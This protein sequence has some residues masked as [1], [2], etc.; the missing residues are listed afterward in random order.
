MSER[1]F[2]D[3]E[4]ISTLL[5]AIRLRFP[6]SIMYVG[7]TA[8]ILSE[9]AQVDRHHFVSQEA[10]NQII[11]LH[12]ETLLPEIDRIIHARIPQP[13]D[14]AGPNYR[15][16]LEKVR[17]GEEVYVHNT[18]FFDGEQGIRENPD[19][20]WARTARLFDRQE[21][22]LPGQ[23][24]MSR[25]MRVIGDDQKSELILFY[26]EPL[27]RTGF[28]VDDFVEGGPGEEAFDGLSAELSARALAFFNQV[29][30][31]G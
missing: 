6:P 24:Q 9:S 2:K 3:Q 28:Q 22:Y 27:D 1:T 11:V 15:F 23:L 12:F 26:M 13:P 10:P 5:P 7:Q 17:L 18:W 20:E 19:K 4:F 8:F 30:V 31:R 16:S 21:V 14:H 29:I 25:Y